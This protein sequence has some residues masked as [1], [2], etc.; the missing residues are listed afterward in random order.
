MTVLENRPYDL[1]SMTHADLATL[2]GL[3]RIPSTT[4]SAIPGSTSPPSMATY[5][6][7]S[8]LRRV[9]V[10]IQLHTFHGHVCHGVEDFLVGFAINPM[11]G[12]DF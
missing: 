10:V 2:H 7:G 8:S 1:L 9:I 11:L 6:S 3:A 12:R 5:I 4:F